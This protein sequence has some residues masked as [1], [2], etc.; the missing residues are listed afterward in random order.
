MPDE[1]VKLWDYDAVAIGQTGTET[2]VTITLDTL[3]EY[4]RATQH[5]RGSELDQKNDVTHPAENSAEN[6]A[7]MAVGVRIKRHA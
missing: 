5:V 6:P 3:R 1:H 4:A 2:T 7:E